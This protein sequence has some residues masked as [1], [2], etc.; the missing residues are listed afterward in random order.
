MYIKVETLK[1]QASDGAVVH[2]ATLMNR[3][4][5]KYNITIPMLN[6]NELLYKEFFSQDRT[7]KAIP[8]RIE[9]HQLNV[10]ITVVEVE[11]YKRE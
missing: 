11:V 5:E 8:I 10:F 3:I 4:L 9:L 7:Y 1:R 6:T 2:P